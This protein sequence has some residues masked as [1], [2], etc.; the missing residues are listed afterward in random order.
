MTQASS[1]TAQTKRPGRKQRQQQRQQSAGLGL[2]ALSLLLL[3]GVAVGCQ[4]TLNGRIYKLDVDA[5][6]VKEG[7]SLLMSLYKE[8]RQ[9]EMEEKLAEVEVAKLQAE[10]EQS[11]SDRQAARMETLLQTLSKLRET[12]VDLEKKIEEQKGEVVEAVGNL[13]ESK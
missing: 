10:L 2:P 12:R 5:V 4:A 13:G 6:A 3:L 1:E 8:Y 11:K 7:S 9:A